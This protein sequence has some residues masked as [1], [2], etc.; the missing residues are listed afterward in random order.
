MRHR[1]SGRKL[2]RPSSHR[3]SLFKNLSIALIEQELIKTTVQKAK[4]LRR[5]IEPLITRA[6]V[7]SVANR[8]LIF[9]KL[10]HLSLIHI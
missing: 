3:K 7:E 4:E 2:N 8:R 10:R 1:K 9:S 6:K 5:F